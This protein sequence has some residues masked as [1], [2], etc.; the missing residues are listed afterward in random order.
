LTQAVNC[1]GCNQQIA[2]DDSPEQT[3]L[4]QLQTEIEQL[5]KEPKMQSFVPAF[6]CKDGTCNQIHSNP[7]FTKLPRGKCRNC[8][9]FSGSKEG[10]CSW[11]KENEIEEIDKDELT[12]LGIELP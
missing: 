11:C 8:E 5:Q 3:Q 6:R 2:I 1:P 4:N 9:Q 12:D 7:R 10:K